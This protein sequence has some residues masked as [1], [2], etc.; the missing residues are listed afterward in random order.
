MPLKSQNWSQR[1]DDILDRYYPTEGGTCAVRLPKRTK[2]AMQTRVQQLKIKFTGSVSYSAKD[3]KQRIKDL[4]DI[5]ASSSRIDP[6]SNYVQEARRRLK[7][8]G[9]S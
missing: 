1:E 4:N 8:L 9:A 6:N 3:L 2:M 7:A 5:I